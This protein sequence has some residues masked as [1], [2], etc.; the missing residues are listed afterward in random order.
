MGI[1]LTGARTLCAV[2][3]GLG[4]GLLAPKVS[5]PLFIPPHVNAGPSMPV[6]LPP[7]SHCTTP[8]LLTSPL[9]LHVSALPTHL[10]ECGFFKSLIVGFPYSLIFWQFWVLFCSLVV[11]LFCC[12]IRRWSLLCLHLDWKPQV[13]YFKTNVYGWWLWGQGG[14][15]GGG[16]EYGRIKGDGKI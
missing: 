9:H 13:L 10:D 7:L 2:Q 12:C 5:L 6:R 3:S 8:H 15:G 14:L 11:I 1:Y 4:L 16:R